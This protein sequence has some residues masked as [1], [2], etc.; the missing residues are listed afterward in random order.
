LIETAVE[1]LTPVRTLTTKLQE[2]A[3]TPVKTLGHWQ[4]TMLS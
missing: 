2:S 4:L 3:L 1:S